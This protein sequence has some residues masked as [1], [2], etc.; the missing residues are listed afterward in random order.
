MCL[1]RHGSVVYDGDDGASVPFDL[2]HQNE[3]CSKK[4]HFCRGLDFFLLLQFKIALLCTNWDG[5]VALSPTFFSML[6]ASNSPEV[7]QPLTVRSPSV[8]LPSRP[9][10]FSS[11]ALCFHQG[12]RD[13]LCP[14][15][16]LAIAENEV[17]RSWNLGVQKPAEFNHHTL[18]ITSDDMLE[19]NPGHARGR[20]II[21]M[22]K[23]FR[24]VESE[25]EVL[26]ENNCGS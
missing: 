5:F 13:A 17:P 4:N 20:L 24:L 11:S 1:L 8:V 12:I 26:I 25:I 18:L 10:S 7:W 19:I 23:V 16:K 2:A 14:A 22:R 21:D 15:P 3:P 6:K 9:D